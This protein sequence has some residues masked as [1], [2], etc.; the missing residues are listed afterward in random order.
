MMAELLQDYDSDINQHLKNCGKSILQMAIEKESTQCTHHLLLMNADPNHW[1]IT[2]KSTPMH[3]VAYTKQKAVEFLELLVK[4][5][6]NINNGVERNGCSVLHHAVYQNNIN[7]VS[8]LLDNKVETVTKTFHE[9]ALHLA[10]EH[11]HHEVIT[12]GSI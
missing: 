12:Q 6:G 1:D 11:D 5:G 2:E 9:T 7:M 3:S 4:F 10:A 8:W